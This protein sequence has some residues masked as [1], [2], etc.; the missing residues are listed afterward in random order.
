MSHT[1]NTIILTRGV[2]LILA[3]VKATRIRCPIIEDR[4][5]NT[6]CSVQ[7]PVLKNISQNG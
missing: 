2:F 4:V 3:S 5:W 7:T 1:L 6:N